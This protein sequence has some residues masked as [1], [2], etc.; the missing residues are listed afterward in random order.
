MGL[1]AHDPADLE[2][3]K[4]TGSCIACDLRGLKKEA[5]YFKRSGVLVLRN[6]DLSH[7]EIEGSFKRAR[8]KGVRLRGAKISAAD[9]KRAVLEGADFSEATLG[10][11]NFAGARLKGATFFNCLISFRSNFN[12]A[13]LRHASFEKCVN[14]NYGFAEYKELQLDFENARLEGV[15]LSGA[16]LRKAGFG[17]SVMTKANLQGVSI[18][19]SYV[20][21]VNLT[22]ANLRGARFPST[23][24]NDTNLSRADLR[25][26]ILS[27]VSF[28]TVDFSGANLKD[29]I[30]SGIRVKGG[31]C[32]ETIMPDGTVCRASCKQCF[33]RNRLSPSES[34]HQALRFYRDKSDYDT[35]RGLLARGADPNGADAKGVTPFMKAARWN[36]KRLLELFLA[37]GARLD[38]RDKKGRTVL[39]YGAMYM[40]EKKQWVALRFLLR[41]GADPRALDRMGRNAL[42]A[43]ARGGNAFEPLVKAGLNVNARDK[44][45]RTALMHLAK[46]KHFPDHAIDA[47]RIEELL[48]LGAKIN[49]RDGKGRTFL[50]RLVETSGLWKGPDQFEERLAVMLIRRGADP[51]ATN[52]M[53]RSLIYTLVKA[54]RVEEIAFFVKHGLRVR[55]SDDDG[56]TPLMSAVIP[57]L[58]DGKAPLDKIRLLL[59]HGARVNARDKRGES[60]LHYALLDE[61]THTRARPNLIAYLLK[62]GAGVRRANNAGK[63]PLDIVREKYGRNDKVR[64]LIENAAR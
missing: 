36:H 32:R 52:V 21:H 50:A 6:A 42:M 41:S 20:A 55:V 49:A 45:G 23:S 22:S 26:A 28:D 7:A 34:L 8:M 47:P 54:G 35:V 48:R 16:R 56:I 4:K 38:A 44:Q 27:G 30:I 25:G 13:D 63:S 58:K 12:G 11:A 57:E 53:G 1:S 2:Q 51:N 24:F 59:K 15:N 29:A 64:R 31:A 39:H 14:P 5:F 40:D 46:R 60:V 61:S 9:F 18:S 10:N 19:E 33:S 3:L 43:A 37:R 17:N 62:K